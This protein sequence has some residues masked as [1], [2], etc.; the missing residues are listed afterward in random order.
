MDA[1]RTPDDRFADL[2]GYPFEPHYVEIPDGDG[3]TLRVHHLDEGDPTA[4]VVLLLHGEPCWSYLYRHMIPVLV[5]AGLR[6]VAPDLVGFGRS[7][8]PAAAHRLHLRPPRRL[9]HRPTCSTSSTCATSR[10][11]ARTGAACSGCASWPRSPTASPASWPPTPSCPPATARP[12]DAFLAWQ[13][14]SQEVPEMPI[15]RIVSGGCTTDLSDEVIAAYDAPFP[16]ETFKEGARQFPLL[17]PTSPDDPEAPANRAAWEVL[18]AFDRPFVCAFSDQDPVTAGNERHLISRIAGR[19][20]PAPHH[21]RRRRPLPAGGPRA[22]A[23]PGRDRPHRPP[24]AGPQSTL[25][26]VPSPG[27]RSRAGLSTRRATASAADAPSAISRASAP[28]TH[29]RG[30]GRAAPAG[31]PRVVVGVTVAVRRPRRRST[32]RRTC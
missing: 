16:D 13:K 15:G 11:S 26:T 29:R 5:D 2:P 14:F 21:H 27:I 19:A 9:A 8:K 24:V 28:A 20:G 25:T 30:E 12:S 3:G 17:V 10:S 1:L 7:D 31:P 32:R 4:P 22:G 6:A 18:A 23:G